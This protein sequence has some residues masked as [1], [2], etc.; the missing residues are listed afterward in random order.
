MSEIRG[1]RLRSPMVL[2]TLVSRDSFGSVLILL[3]ITYTLAVVGRGA[4][5]SL[6]LALQAITV[7]LSVHVSKARRGVRIAANV[8]LVFAGLVAIA[9]LLADQATTLRSVA[10][11]ASSLLYF[12]APISILR[13]IVMRPQVD[14]E[15]VLGAIDAYLMIGMFFAFIYQA[16]GS[17]GSTPFFGRGVEEAAGQYLFFSF[18]TLTTTGYGNL[19]PATPSGQTLA[20]L[21]MLIGQLFL[22]TA[23]AKVISAWQP[24][25]WKAIRE[26]EESSAGR[27]DETRPHG[28]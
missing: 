3:L 27:D 12:I 11:I 15:A 26:G 23:V 28:P 4:T 21:E 19:V 5:Q 7:W 22:V 14:R 2:R 20:V 1:R 18:T 6:V 25:R 9:Y 17:L 10:F 13:A 8:A 16:E 24:V